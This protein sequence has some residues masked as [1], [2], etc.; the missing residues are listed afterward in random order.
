MEL[1][2]QPGQSGRLGDRLQAGFK[3]NWTHFRAAA[4]FV[5]RSGVKHIASS[6][7]AFAR[8]GKVEIIAG[9]DHNGTSY[10]GLRD[11]LQA[12]APDGRV[13]VFHNRAAHTF[14]PKVYLFRS[15]TAAEVIIG[16]GNLTEGGL[17]TNYEASLQLRL[18]RTKS[19][20]AALLQSIETA[21][22]NWADQTRGTT[23]LLD[24]DFL[25][26]LKDQH[27]VLAEASTS[28]AGWSRDST[29]G[30]VHQDTPFA[31]VS[32]HT[33]P[34]AALLDNMEARRPITPEEGGANRTLDSTFGVKVFVMTLQNTD[35]GVGQ[36]STGTSRRSPEIFIPLSARDA[37]P[38]FWDWPTGFTEDGAKPG[39]FDRRAR[40]RFGEET[41]QVQMMTWPDRHDFRLRSEAL[42]SAGQVGDILRIEQADHAQNLDYHASVIPKDTDEHMFHLM[43]CKGVVRHSKKRYGYFR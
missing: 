1:L 22:D 14:H 35:V 43:H 9:I 18:D 16:S 20:H 3:G 37:D 4:A 36:T 39:K 31:A 34:A 33:A 17:F 2:L 38:A 40:I 19:S 25:N 30:A 42:R 10:E 28:S 8:N 23:H 5:K 26:L 41:I 24:E 13:L 32:E 6:L 27:L 11:L 12:T 29:S 7:K 15:A 21:L